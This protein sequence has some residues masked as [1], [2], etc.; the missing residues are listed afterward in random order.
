TPTAGGNAS[1][2]DFS[3]I[4]WVLTP[5][6]NTVPTVGSTILLYVD[7]VYLG[8]A[9]YNQ[10]RPDIEALFPGYN[11]SAGAMA[12]FNLDTTLYDNGVH[13]IYWIATDD[14]DNSDGIGSRYFNIQNTGAVVQSAGNMMGNIDFSK[15]PME[16]LQ[17]VSVTKGYKH[18]AVARQVLPGKKGFVTIKSRELERVVVDL[19]VSGSKGYLVVGKQLRALPIGSTF[20]AEKGIFYW[21]P[22]PGFLGEYRFL[23][24]GKNNTRKMIK[25]KIHQK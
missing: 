18:D 9:T 2:S 11:N 5:P 1:G 23:F 7:G 19:G 15:L 4:G 16:T 20:D 6:P 22:G 17:P 3:N 14:A 8:T 13:T 24:I 25:I 21:Q 12:T 10:N